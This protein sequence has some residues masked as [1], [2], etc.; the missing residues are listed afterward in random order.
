MYWRLYL[1]K[2]V[3]I[4]IE[5]QNQTRKAGGY[6]RD[7]ANSYAVFSEIE[8]VLISIYGYLSFQKQKIVFF[9]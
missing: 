9:P 2:Y 1:L 5:K 4:W 6:A 3:L 8:R 7:E